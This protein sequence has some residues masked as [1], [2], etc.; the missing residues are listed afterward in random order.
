[1]TTRDDPATSGPKDL[2]RYGPPD[3]TVVHGRLLAAMVERDAKPSD[4]A[5]ATGVKWQNV[6]LWLKGEV[7]NIKTENLAAAAE[8]LGCSLDWL[9]TGKGALVNEENRSLVDET[10]AA[11]EAQGKPVSLAAAER[12]RSLQYYQGPMTRGQADAQL[13]DIEAAEA[14]R[15]VGVTPLGPPPRD[16]DKAPLGL[17]KKLR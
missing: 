15:S 4:V 12:F 7:A 3:F 16:P 13:R 6:D 10:L 9:I 17:G 1:M 14:G 2:S 5:K 8:Y 11:R